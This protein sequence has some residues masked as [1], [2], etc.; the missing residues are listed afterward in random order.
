MSETD[1]PPEEAEKPKRLSFREAN[2]GHGHQPEPP[3]ARP[4]GFLA[5]R[6]RSVTIGLLAVGAGAAAIYGIAHSNQNCTDTAGQATS[7]GRAGSSGGG[8]RYFGSSG[9]S[10]SES[11]TASR[12]G[13]GGSGA[14]HA[15]GGE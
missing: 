8:A 13:F 1:E 6:K 3:P 4:P 15:S 14:A 10:S 12:G 11:S 2:L 5:R 9:S 7:C